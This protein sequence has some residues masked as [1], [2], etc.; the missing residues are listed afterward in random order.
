ML[1]DTFAYDANV[2]VENNTP[3]IDTIDPK[4][5]SPMTIMLPMKIQNCKSTRLMKI[6]LDSGSSHCIINRRCLP[7]NCIPMNCCTTRSDTAAGIF[8]MNHS[9][10]LSDVTLPEF[11][12]HTNFERVN[13]YVFD[14]PNSRYDIITGRDFLSQA[15][16]ILNFTNHT[17]TQNKGRTID[18]KPP[19]FWN[20]PMNMYLTLMDDT[21]E[22][23]EEEFASNILPSKYEKV[24]IDQVIKEQTHLDNDQKKD[25]KHAL[26]QYPILFNGQLGEYQKRKIH[27][28]LK[29]NPKPFH[30][31]AYAV[32][33]VHLPVYKEELDRLQKVGVLERTGESEWAAGSFITIKKDGR[34][35]W[36]SDFRELNKYIQRKVYPLPRIQDVL[37]RRA[38][39]KYFTKIDI[40]MQYYT[41]VLDE[42]SSKLCTIVTPFG[43]YRYLRLPMGVCQSSD[44]AQ[45]IMEEILR[46]MKEVEIYIDD[47]GIFSNDWETHMNSVHNVLDKL[48]KNG[49]TVNPLKCE[50]AVQE[51]D[52][53]GYWLTPTGLKPWSKKIRAIL[54]W[55][56]PKT[57]KQVRSFL[58]AVNFYREMWPRRAHILAPLTELTGKQPFIWTVRQQTAF[59]E[60]KALLAKDA[61]VSYPDHNKPF[62]IFTDASDYQLGAVIMQDNKPVAYYSKKLNPAQKNYTTMEKELL[63]VVATLRDYRTMLLGAEIHIH[64]DHKNNTYRNLT[65][66]RVLRWRLLLEDFNPTFHYIEGAQNT[67]AD[68]CSRVT[69]NEEIMNEKNFVGPN[70]KPSEAFSLSIDDPTA[71][72]IFLN[73]PREEELQN[74]LDYR[75]I[76]LNQFDDLN[77][78]NL[79]RRFPNEYPIV[80]VGQNIQLISKYNP[81]HTRTYI[82]IPERSLAPIVVWYHLMLNHCGQSKLYETIR[83]NFYN[84]DLHRT[85]TAV[86]NACDCQ[87][88]KPISRGYGHLP[89]RTATMIP[90]QTVCVDLIGPWKIDVN[91]Q[92]IIF[93]ALTII[94]PDTNLADATRIINKTS[95][96]VAMHFENTWLSRYPW[97]LRCVHDQRKE[98]I[99]FEFLNMLRRNNIQSVPTTVKNPQGNSI[100]E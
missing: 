59:D 37:K 72:E 90:F 9:V 11:N 1:I 3:I 35:R 61:I 36:V 83:L 95:R 33:H 53:L 42:E 44:V 78:Q 51:T 32:P 96:H 84:P 47:I 98:F 16:L 27:L 71:A 46:D 15:Q 87:K 55:E 2:Y 63:G 43:K 69:L 79:R 60:M 93:N 7:K 38:G 34:V 82:A 88:D 73:H 41:F 64:T 97:P 29:P 70:N 23:E 39:Y 67:I 31:K 92:E 10:C 100:C 28:E 54:S 50:W 75:T 13:A 65:S 99:G 14:Q 56:R 17:V 18:M 5:L 58:G 40:S 57:V 49:L 12:R 8:T 86:V 20:D 94:D 19:N 62:H 91:H 6:L 30:S 68:W 85:C 80:D 89:P 76:Q 52:W 81:L 48:Q 45:C 26:E 74:P 66:Q 25:L 22:T 21:D 24:E 77:L 4:I